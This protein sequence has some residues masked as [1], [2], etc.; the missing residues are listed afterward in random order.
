MKGEAGRLTHRLI[1]NALSFIGGDLFYHFVNF[2]AGILVARSLGSDAYGK[3]SFI[4]V[5]LSFFEI[6]VQF[7]MNS[8]L[9]REVSRNRD[10]APRILGNAFLFRL[11]LMALAIPAALFLIQGL[12]YAPPVRQG[13][14]IASLLL[15]LGFR[16]I[17]ETIFKVNLLMIYPALWNGVRAVLNLALIAFFAGFRPELH[18]FILCYV[19]TGLLALAGL[20]LFSRRFVRL[21]FK[22]DLPL[23]ARLIRESFPLILSGCLTLLYVRVDVFML[24]KMKSF[25]EV[26]FYGVAVRLTES[27]DIIATSVMISLFPLLSRAFKESREEFARISQKAVEI[28]FLAGLPLAAG[29]ILVADELIVFLFGTEFAPAGLTLKILCGYTFFGFWSIFLVN[30]LIACGRQIVDMWIS[31]FLLG[32]NVLLNFILIP[33]FSYNGAAAA[34]VLTEIFGIV[35]MSAYAAKNKSIALAPPRRELAA[36]LKAN[37][38]LLAALFL[39]KSLFRAPMF[40][41]ILLAAPVYPLILFSMGVLSWPGVRGYAASLWTKIQ[42]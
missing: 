18:L 21:S 22:I 4:F 1:D 20:A 33:H 37:A 38:F 39:A 36:A 23:I 28:L 14:G 6:F 24:S 15:F 11:A 29:G 30:L 25:T 41:L 12:G 19:C 13:V 27:L 2:L 16:S 34:T 9:T 31:L 26:G 17:F 40:V 7:G 10:D 3:F 32:S 5:Y 35:W 8:V 42:K